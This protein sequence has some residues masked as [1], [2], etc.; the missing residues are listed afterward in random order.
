MKKANPGGWLG[1][2]KMVYGNSILLEAPEPSQAAA[3]AFF[4]RVGEEDERVHRGRCHA[5]FA[6]D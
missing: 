6:R 4:P 3:Y 5:L 1:L 2:Q